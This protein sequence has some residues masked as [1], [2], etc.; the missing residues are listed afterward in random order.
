MTGEAKQDFM[1]RISEANKS[2][3][4]VILYRLKSSG[5]SG[6]SPVWG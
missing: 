5:P 6:I 2:R 4:V 1:L 3:M